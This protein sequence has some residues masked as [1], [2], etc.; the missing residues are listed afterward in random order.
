ML[1]DLFPLNYTK[2]MLDL[3]TK[4]IENSRAKGACQ[5]MSVAARCPSPCVFRVVLAFFP[6]PPPPLPLPLALLQMMALKVVKVDNRVENA[7][8]LMD[9]YSN[10][11]DLLK[12]LQGNRFIINLENSEV[13]FFCRVRCTLFFCLV[14]TKEL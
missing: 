8:A 2:L 12:T 11:I 13:W 3:R 6:P 10:E 9:S 5:V 14:S 7:Q 4:R 1:L